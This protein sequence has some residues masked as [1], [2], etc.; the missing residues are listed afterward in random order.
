V[1]VEVE[2]LA[3][4]ELEVPELLDDGVPVGCVED[5]DDEDETEVLVRLYSWRRFP[6]PQYSVLSPGQRKEQSA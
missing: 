4:P 3:L 2:L 6:A 5:D 1:V